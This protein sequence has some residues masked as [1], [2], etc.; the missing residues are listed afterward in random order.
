MLIQKAGLV[1]ETWD[2]R[3][4]DSVLIVPGTIKLKGSRIFTLGRTSP[5]SWY[6]HEINLDD[7]FLF[8]NAIG[9]RRRGK[10]NRT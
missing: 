1:E 6:G 5:C 7:A 4:A 3:T 9:G 2:Q 8:E 10:H